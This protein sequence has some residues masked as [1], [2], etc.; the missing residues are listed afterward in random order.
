MSLPYPILVRGSLPLVRRSSFAALAAALAT[1]LLAGAP[2][3]AHASE[4]KK[5]YKRLKKENA[6]LEADL[7][8]KQAES[9]AAFNEATAA[10]NAS[11]MKFTVATA[12]AGPGV[13]DAYP[14]AGISYVSLHVRH[15]DYTLVPSAFQPAR[16]VGVRRV[17]AAVLGFQRRNK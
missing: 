9:G 12:V 2:T 7:A 14:A 16:T 3:R 5:E 15:A 1:L 6:S 11:G 10:E 13:P 17:H 4:L 8:K